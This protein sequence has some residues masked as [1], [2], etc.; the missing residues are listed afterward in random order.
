MSK[1]SSEILEQTYKWKIGSASAYSA[2]VQEAMRYDKLRSVEY[3]IVMTI[4]NAVSK[5]YAFEKWQEEQ[6]RMVQAF[7]LQ[8]PDNGIPHADAAN[9]YEQLVGCLNDLSLWPW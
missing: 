9:R 7:T 2:L 8:P 6:Q 1:E 4:L 3:P 5:G